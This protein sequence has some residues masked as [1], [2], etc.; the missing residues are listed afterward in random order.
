M[1]YIGISNVLKF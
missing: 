1:F